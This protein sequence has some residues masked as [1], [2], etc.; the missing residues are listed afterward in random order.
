M[1]Y[2]DSDKDVRK[3]QN[4]TSPTMKTHILCLEMVEHVVDKPPRELSAAHSAV[5][6]CVAP[7]CS[8][9]DTLSAGP[10][11]RAILC[12]RPPT[13][14]TLALQVNSSHL[15]APPTFMTYRMFRDPQVLPRVH[16]SAQPVVPQRCSVVV[17][18]STETLH[19]SING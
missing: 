17:S 1:T 16:Y 7:H 4:P 5:V 12:E 3:G 19:C 8:G 13:M 18:A 6:F 9:L 15:R 11:S 14:G 2:K 10:R